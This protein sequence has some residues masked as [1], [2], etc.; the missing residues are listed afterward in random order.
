M[1]PL[2]KK[3]TVLAIG[4]NRKTWFG[5]PLCVSISEWPDLARFVSFYEI[6][7]MALMLLKA[8]LKPKKMLSLNIIHLKEKIVL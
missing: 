6:R 1:A 2:D 8:F 4:K 3:K 7:N 5:H